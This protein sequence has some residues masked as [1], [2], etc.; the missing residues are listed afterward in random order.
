ME[1]SP[2]KDHSFAVLG[3]ALLSAIASSLCCLGPLIYLVFGLSAAG[4]TGLGR[5]SR[6]QVPLAAL[7]LLFVG[8]GFWNLY[9]SSKP[10]CAGR[11]SRKKTLLIYWLSV[12]V[13]LF[14]VLYPSM[15]PL[16]LEAS[17]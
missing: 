1:K 2:R 15:L 6:L 7:S 9:F 10:V 5:L 4:L 13:I 11:L 17:E 8:Y 16:I 12:P 14:F 3:G